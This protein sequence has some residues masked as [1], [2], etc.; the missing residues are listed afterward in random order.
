MRCG[1]SYVEV[2][3]VLG[4]HRVRVPHLGAGEPGEQ[5]VLDLDAGVGLAMSLPDAG[6]AGKGSIN[7]T[8]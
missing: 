6:P 3:A 4:Q 1:H 5:S 8:A 2:E 7:N